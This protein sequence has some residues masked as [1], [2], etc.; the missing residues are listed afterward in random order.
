MSFGQKGKEV[1]GSRVDEKRKPFQQNWT[2]TT[3]HIKESPPTHTFPMYL[4]I[5]SHDFQCH[6]PHFLS[7][8]FVQ[9][10]VGSE[11]IVLS[12]LGTITFKG[13]SMD[14]TKEETDAW[15]LL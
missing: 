2:E 1:V 15:A 11:G 4:S 14:I 7:R 6:Q 8:A 9:M 10:F 3:T 5:P 12:V 13:V